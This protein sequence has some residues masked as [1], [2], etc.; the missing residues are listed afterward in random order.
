MSQ[1]AKFNDDRSFN[2]YKIDAGEI[3]TI[4]NADINLPIDYD[5][6]N[7]LDTKELN[8]LISKT[9]LSKIT[10]VVEKIDKISREYDFINADLEETKTSKNQ[11]SLIF[12][13]KESEKFYVEDKY[14]WE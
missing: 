11:I 3:Y 5:E 14:P 2:I 13:I 10:R 8:K 6:N 1:T 9:H 4:S 12:N 7:F